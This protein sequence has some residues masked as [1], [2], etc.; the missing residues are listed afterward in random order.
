MGGEPSV[1][2]IE[3]R[4]IGAAQA[5][6][7]VAANHYSGRFVRNSQLHL[8]A[9]LNG[10]L[11]GVMQFGPPFDKSKVIGLVK[12]TGWSEMLELNRM[13]FDK[14]LPKNSESRCLAIAFRLIRKN[15][16]HV[17]WILSFSDGTQSGDGTIY[18]ATGFLLTGINRNKSIIRLPDGTVA[19]KMTFTKG[20]HILGQKG[21]AA[22]PPG[23]D[24]LDGFQLRYV[25]LLDS[26]ATIAVPVLPYSAI[27]EAG[28]GMY[29]GKKRP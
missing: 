10:R 11:H 15:A 26:T 25:K 19:A 12:N 4:V 3:V 1:K 20:K 8:G 21:K 18:R 17:K 24:F 23:S 6:A 28:A 2:D 5:N 14:Y 16:P 13:A 27:K 7:F 22:P 9:F 29:L